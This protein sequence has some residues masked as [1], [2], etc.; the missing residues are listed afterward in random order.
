MSRQLVH[1]ADKKLPFQTLRSGS[2]Q[3][4]FYDDVTT[5]EGGA[6]RSLLKFTIGKR[7]RKENGDYQTVRTLY[8]QDLAPM[9]AL[10]QQAQAYALAEQLKAD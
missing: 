10:L 3:V 8:L 4:A 9:A 7:I 6:E 2:L 1:D 5:A